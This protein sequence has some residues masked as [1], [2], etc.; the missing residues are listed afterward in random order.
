MNIAELKEA[1]ARAADTAANTAFAAKMAADKAAKAA[2]AA[3]AIRKIANKLQEDADVAD[4]EAHNTKGAA[5]A[6]AMAFAKAKADIRFAYAGKQ[7]DMADAATDI[8]VKALAD[9]DKFA[10]IAAADCQAALSAGITDAHKAWQIAG[11]SAI[12]AAEA[13]HTGAMAIEAADDAM[14]IADDAMNIAEECQRNYHAII[15][16]RSPA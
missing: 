15:Y 7:Q 6:A 3:K 14:N 16:K 10:R 4:V 13:A 11:Q 12:M 1:T 2:K 8:E 9:A 5:H